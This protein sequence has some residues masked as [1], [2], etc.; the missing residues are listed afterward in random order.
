MQDFITRS[1][2]EILLREDYEA[3]ICST[4]DG[5]DLDFRQKSRQ[6]ILL[7]ISAVYGGDDGSRTHVRKHVQST[8][9][10]R[11]R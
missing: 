9:S 5:H 8:F 10:E 1:L 4:R 11:S 7:V 3:V 6:Q 2:R